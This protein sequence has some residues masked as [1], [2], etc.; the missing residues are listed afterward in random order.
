MLEKGATVIVG[1]RAQNPVDA[2]RPLAGSLRD[3]RRLLG[4][5]VQRST[6]STSEGALA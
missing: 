5:S 2:E 6:V 3:P 1:S 4:L